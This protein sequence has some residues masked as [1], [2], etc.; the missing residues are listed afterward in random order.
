MADVPPCSRGFLWHGRL[1]EVDRYEAYLADLRG[2]SANGS[3]VRLE[4]SLHRLSRQ[5]PPVDVPSG[6]EFVD[7]AI[8]PF[9][10]HLR[11]QPGK[12]I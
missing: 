4:E 10:S 8:G 1:H 6:V 3:E 7:G 5:A 9:V 11:E 2:E 12:D